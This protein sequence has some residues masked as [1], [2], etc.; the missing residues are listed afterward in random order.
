LLRDTVRATLLDSTLPAAATLYAAGLRWLQDARASVHLRRRD[1][2]R[3][4]V[5][6]KF[7]D[8]WRSR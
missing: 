4:G 6:I 2:D 5:H 7:R 3:I 1:L 8:H